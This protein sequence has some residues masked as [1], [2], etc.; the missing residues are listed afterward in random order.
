MKVDKLTAKIAF[1]IWLVLNILCMYNVHFYPPAGYSANTFATLSKIVQFIYIY[2]VI[3]IAR[4]VYTNRHNPDVKDEICV[5]LAYFVPVILLFTF[6]WP[7][8][9]SWDDVFIISGTQWWNPSAWQHFFSGFM[10]I[11]FLL[12][13]PCVAGVVIQ[14]IFVASLIVAYCIPR[15]ARLF[16][17]TSRQ[18]KIYISLLLLPC[19]FPPMLVYIYAG[20]RI[21]IYCYLELLLLCYLLL[22]TNLAS[23][24]K[25]YPWFVVSLTSVVA[26]WRSEAFYYPFVVFVILLL[27]SHVKKEYIRAVKIL[28]LTVL[29]T[30]AIGKINNRLIGNDNYTVISVVNPI[31][32]IVRIVDEEKFATELQQIDKV[33]NIDLIKTTNFSGVALFW[34][35]MPNFIRYDHSQT[36][37]RA[38][39]SACIRLIFAYPKTA[40]DCMTNYFVRTSGVAGWSEGKLRASGMY[41][42]ALDRKGL[43]DD[44]V[45]PGKSF[46]S[47][48]S[49]LKK[50]LFS[51][52]LREKAILH[53]LCL[54]ENRQAK[55]L[56][57]V[58]YN[59]W[60]PF[61]LL[62]LGMIYCLCKRDWTYF[63]LYAL[64]S[65]RVVPVFLTALSC[66]FFYYLSSYFCGYF[67]SFLMLVRFLAWK[68][69]KQK[70]D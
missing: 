23:G 33:I 53:L 39:L 8:T 48:R 49:P 2:F 9:W 56:Y 15:V 38:Y 34:R 28:L 59:H 12:N 63:W 3:N 21:G 22:S 20:Y 60:I 7:G 1:I 35:D 52:R 41:I 66:F 65:A 40:L 29:F 25:F 31:T 70:I 46:T 11:V 32:D 50:P 26:S 62:L 24:V 27:H 43:Y 61:L 69:S 64:V 17:K 13:I 44:T 47:I 36:E 68:N 55:W 54:D 30:F 18:R 45:Q 42:C 16:A 14:Q 57:F 67:L 5:F 6:F 4:R 37:Y 58:F 19:F 10:Q 51:K